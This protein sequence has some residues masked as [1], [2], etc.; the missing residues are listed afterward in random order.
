MISLTPVVELLRP[1]PAGFPRNWF[2][3][4]GGGC[5][6]AAIRPD[7]LPL[8]AAWVVRASDKG[9]PV[10]ER[11]ARTDAGFDVVIAIQ[12]LRLT[13]P[14]QMDDELLIYRRAVFSVLCGY[15]LD[16]ELQPIKWLG[17]KVLEYTDGDVYWAD[18][19]EFQALYTNYLPDPPAFAG[20]SQE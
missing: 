10:G 4:V 16:P 1:V 6:Y 13:D 14:R 3:A 15:E 20:V 12:N 19:Y 9:I 2:R 18:R 11:A 7:A 17:G 8:P 5:E